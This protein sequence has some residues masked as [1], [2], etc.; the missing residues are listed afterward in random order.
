[1]MVQ[2][3]MTMLHSDRG[4][5]MMATILQMAIVVI[6]AAPFVLHSRRLVQPAHIDS[7]WTPR[8][9]Y[10]RQ[11]LQRIWWWL[12]REEFWRAVQADT[13]RCVELT[14]MILLL[15]WMA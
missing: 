1:M 6:W 2:H 5:T 13:I 14:L 15:A 12:G 9:Q 3:T 10:L 7:G 8:G 4:M 11:H